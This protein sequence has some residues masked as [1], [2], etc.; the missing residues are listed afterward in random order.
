M[1]SSSGT[2]A[3]VPLERLS[4]GEDVRKKREHNNNNNNDRAQEFSVEEESPAGFSGNDHDDVDDDEV[5]GDQT[6][7][8]QHV[9]PAPTTTTCSTIQPSE[10]DLETALHQVMQNDASEK[11]FLSEDSW[12]TFRVGHAGDASTIASL[13]RSTSSLLMPPSSEGG[14]GKV[15]STDDGKNSKKLNDDTDDALELRLAAGLGD[16][17]NPPALFCVFADVTTKKHTDDDDGGERKGDVSGSATVTQIGA[18]ALFCLDW[19]LGTRLLRIEWFHVD[20]TITE[21]DLVRRRVWFRLSALALATSCQLL[22]P[23]SAAA[24]G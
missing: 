7:T 19:E 1:V 24:E 3:A 9:A 4:G 20:E 15:V 22:L 5:D 8:N 14:G 17:D 6:K 18:V 23:H 11:E 12:I 16:E 2:G 10:I 21:R 13:F